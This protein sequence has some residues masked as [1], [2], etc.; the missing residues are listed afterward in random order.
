MEQS[1]QYK[2]HIINNNYRADSNKL[3][4]YVKDIANKYN[5]NIAAKVVQHKDMN[6]H[7]RQNDELSEEH[8]ADGYIASGGTGSWKPTGEKH[9]KTGLPY[10]KRSNRVYEHLVKKGATVYGICE[11]FKAV[12]QVYGANSVNSGKLNVNKEQGLK[13]KYLIP[14]EHQ[15]KLGKAPVSTED[16]QGTKYL[17]SFEKG[18]ISGTQHHPELRKSQE[19]EQQ[20]V[21]F[22]EKATGQ[23]A[24]LEEKVEQTI[25]LEKVREEMMRREHGQQPKEYEKAA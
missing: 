6:K 14:V 24:N 25:K 16:H 15:D 10:M 13:H 3:L 23:K 22:L 9:A 4:N 5:F 2:I 18:N 20:I 19:D 12:A 21:R 17:T 8:I 11:G 7:L 1:K